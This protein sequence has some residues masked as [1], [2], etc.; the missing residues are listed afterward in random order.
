[1]DEGRLKRSSMGLILYKL[2]NRIVPVEIDEDA[3]DLIS[4]GKP[5]KGRRNDIL[6]AMTVEKDL[7]PE[8]CIP[9]ACNDLRDIGRKDILLNGNRSGHSDVM[10]GMASKP[11]RLRN[12]AARLLGHSLSHARHEKGILSIAGM[13][14]MTF[15]ASRQE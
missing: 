4:P 6:L 8:A 15:G 5:M 3:R 1:M 10:V 2:R 13:E 12:R 11:D 7:F 9:I 14:A